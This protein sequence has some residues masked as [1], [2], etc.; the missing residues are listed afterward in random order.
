[1]GYSISMEKSTLIP[2]LFRTEYSKIVAV[3]CNKYGYAFLE[4]AEDIVSDTFLKAS[5]A[6]ISGNPPNPAA[7]LYKVAQNKALDMF[8][9]KKIFQEKVSPYIKEQSALP[10]DID[11]SEEEILDSQL[12]MM[13]VL[14]N[15]ELP[16]EAQISLAL[17]ILGGFGIEE[18]AHAFLTSKDTINKRLYRAKQKISSHPPDFEL[19]SPQIQQ[20][21]ESVLRIIYL[22]FNEGYF[23]FSQTQAIRQELC[24]EALRL[25]LLLTQNPLTNL[26]QVNAL[27]ALMCY[28]A[29][30][31]EARAQSLNETTDFEEGHTQPSNPELV[32]K[33]DEYMNRAAHGRVLSK[34]HLEAAIAYWHTQPESEEKWER[35]LQLYNL[36]LQVEYSPMIALNRT[37][38]LAKAR[39]VDQAIK[40]ALKIKLEN[41][42]LYFSLLAKLYES[43]SLKKSIE[44]LQKGL[45]LAK[46]EHDRVYYQKRINAL[47]KEGS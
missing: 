27:V 36:L 22:L 34:Y 18:I 47:K 5:S 13:F 33:G 15:N 14:C 29:S 28:H 4:E 10:Q 45:K 46:N 44:Y 3:L 9:R 35:I 40:E 25:G 11:F 6:W 30:R 8:R 12:K 31:L 43:K 32:Q 2:H 26:P 19:K 20:G 17:K 41:N 38:A 42:H 16:P 21:I 39:S 7:W 1:M 23:S 37:Y 24:R